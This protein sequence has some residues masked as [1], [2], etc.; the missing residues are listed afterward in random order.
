MNK[1]QEKTFLGIDYGTKRIG[2]AIGDTSSNVAKAFKI[3]HQFKELKDIVPAK[4]I[5]AFVIGLP[6]QPDG[7]EGLVCDN[8]RLFAQ[9]LQQEFSLPI[10]WVDERLDRKSVV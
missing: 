5:Q 2:L 3:I 7:T 8:A 6:L 9:K 10:Y 1:L 4:Q